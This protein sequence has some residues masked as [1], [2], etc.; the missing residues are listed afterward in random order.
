[1]ERRRRF[2]DRAR[3][4][5]GLLSDLIDRIPE[6]RRERA[7]SALATTFGRAPLRSLEQITT[8]A[9]ALSYRIEVSGRPY[10]LRLESSRR[11][12]I[13]DP[14]RSYVCMRLAAEA[15]IAPAVHHADPDA[16]VAIT[17]FVPHRSIAD[18]WA[19]PDLARDLGNLVARLQAIPAFPP[20]I[21][22]PTTVGILLDRLVETD[23][24]APGLLDPHREG[25]ERIREAWRWNTQALVSS[26]N[27]LNPGNILFDGQRLWVID[28]ETAYLNDPLVDVATLTIFIAAPP[29]LEAM[30]LKAWLG[31]EP[32]RLERARLALMRL[33]VRLF[34][35]CAASL[36]AAHG[37]GT[38][39]PA[40]DLEAP[41]RA[42][43]AAE[44]EQAGLSIGSP[45]AQRLFGKMALAS[46]LAG[47]AT[48]EFEDAIKQVRS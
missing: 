44:V 38:V 37:L 3:Q 21:D 15:G 24:F 33:L 30:L 14:H 1:M 32:D 2:D 11:D 10:L 7:R 43:L 18:L 6:D 45:K 36:N 47:V 16:A 22:Y 26:H 8:G 39:I 27:D 41:T 13:R 29:E 20:L 12:E 31:R 34:Y 4:E 5:A 40:T 9:S 19:S 42:Q 48:P 35:G 46:F 25:F 23:L 28:W 17:D